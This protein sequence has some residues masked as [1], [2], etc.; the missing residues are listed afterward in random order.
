MAK[1]LP[2]PV[3]DRQRRKLV[4]EWMDDHQPHYES[5][6]Q[7]SLTQWIKSQPLY[8]R[9]YALY[10]NSRWST[11]EIEP[12]IRKY[13]INMAEFEQVRYRSFAEFFDR[14]FR[15]GVRK[16]PSAPEEMGA[17]AEARYFG[18]EKVEPDQK[19][20]VKGPHSAPSKF[21]VVRSGPIPLPAAPSFSYVSPPSTIIIC[22]TLMMDIH[23]TIIG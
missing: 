23:W 12:F 8:D 4:E 21:S 7:R 11:R 9:L 20:P 22:T 6:P 15:S 17:F 16:F 3:W 5:E 1:P 19:F 2:L 10:E 14:R 13:H 18:W